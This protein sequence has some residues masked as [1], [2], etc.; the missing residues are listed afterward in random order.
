MTTES[1]PATSSTSWSTSPRVWRGATKPGWNKSA[2]P[3]NGPPKKGAEP[4]GWKTTER[5]MKMKSNF[6]E[7]KELRHAG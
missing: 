2:T 5:P 4:L 3:T 6:S 1:S 7:N